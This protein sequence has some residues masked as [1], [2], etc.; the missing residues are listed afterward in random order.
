MHRELKIRSMG[1]GPDLV[2][3]H[4][5]AMHSGMWG[6]AVEGLRSRFRVHLVDL[7]GHGFN[8][9][10]DL[11]MTGEAISEAVVARVPGAFW[12]GWSLGGM[13]AMEAAMLAPGSVYSLLLVA[14]PPCFVRN[15][16]WPQ[17]M[18]EDVFSQFS[19]GL[20]KNPEATIK[21]FLALEVHGSEN[22]ALKLR[23]LK[24]LYN[25]APGPRMDALQAGL[26]YLCNTDLSRDLEKVGC[27]SLLIG[28]SHD[29]LVT[30]EA[31]K[32]AARQLPRTQLKMI[33]GAGH[34]PFIGHHRKLVNMVSD[35]VE[36]ISMVTS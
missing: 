21:R 34:A 26:Q 10:C 27:V 30:P 33:R 25:E 11:P 36:S 8:H 2:M 29:R 19:E 13:L 4:G 22:A 5:W 31:L 15:P 18:D 28:G 23:R 14:A 16:G 17:G 32:Q 9:D 3:L 24:E 12:L 6:Q 20:I 35:F 7:P 1:D